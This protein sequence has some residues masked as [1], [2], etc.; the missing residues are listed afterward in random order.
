M[1]MAY[2]HADKI[3]RSAAGEAPALYRRDD[4]RRILAARDIGA[5]YRAINDAGVAQRR[6]AELTGQS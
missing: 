4:V 2:G 5:L 1:T 3:A 6:I